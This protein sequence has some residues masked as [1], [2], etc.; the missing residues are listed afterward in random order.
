MVRVRENGIHHGSSVS[1]NRLQVENKSP[2]TDG[3][4]EVVV[5]TAKRDEPGTQTKPGRYISVNTR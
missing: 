2:E 5:A 4:A 3:A 1:T